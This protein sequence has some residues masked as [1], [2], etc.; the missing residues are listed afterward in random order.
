L[1]SVAIKHLRKCTEGGLGMTKFLEIKTVH[2]NIVLINIDKIVQITEGI[3]L[4]FH[5]I[6]LHNGESIK[7]YETIEEIKA[8]L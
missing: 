3:E 8:K 7:T 1:Q 6:W 5:F 2:G 4:D